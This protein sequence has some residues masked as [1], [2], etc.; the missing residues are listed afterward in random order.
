[1]EINNG[2]SYG[3]KLKRKMY[4]VTIPGNEVNKV[5]LVDK[6]AVIIESLSNRN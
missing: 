1:V 5:F 4:W 2:N 6:L 3:E